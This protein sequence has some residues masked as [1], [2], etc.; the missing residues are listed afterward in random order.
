MGTAISGLVVCVPKTGCGEGTRGEEELGP[1]MSFPGRGRRDLP[2]KRESLEKL[3]QGE[4]MTNGGRS[5]AGS[6]LKADGR[7]LGTDRE[8]WELRRRIQKGLQFEQGE[9]WDLR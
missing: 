4:E 7:G 1:G 6:E 9:G 5:L 8:G 3:G 2:G